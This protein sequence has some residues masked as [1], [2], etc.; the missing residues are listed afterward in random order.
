MAGR[1][2]GFR[3]RSEAED[4]LVWPGAYHSFSARLT[5]LMECDSVAVSR[6]LGKRSLT[7]RHRVVEYGGA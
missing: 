4:N 7:V 2:R 6:G 3:V 5:A 1:T